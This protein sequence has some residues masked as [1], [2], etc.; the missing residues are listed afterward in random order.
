MS[1]GNFFL[2]FNAMPSSNS[3]NRT[4][5]LIKGLFISFLFLGLYHEGLKHMY[6]GWSKGD[7][8]Y[9]YI[10]PFVVLYLLWDKRDKLLKTPSAP[11]WKGLIA[12][13]PGLALFWL[14]ELGGEYFTLYLAAWITLVGI[15]WLH[16]GWQK[17]KIIRF[18]LLMIPAMFP[19]PNFFHFRL[20]L[21]LKLLS[22]RFG[23]A[24]MQWYGLS[25]FRQGN[26]IDLGFTQLQVV[27]A[28]N[29]IRYLFPLFFL[30]LL[31][32]YHTRAA[33]WKKA[34]L[35]VSTIPLAVFTNSLRIALTGI[36]YPYVGPAIVKGF[37]HD[38]AG[39]FIFMCSLGILIPEMW[40]LKRIFPDRYIQRMEDSKEKTGTD[41]LT[42]NI[43]H[44]VG[45]KKLKKRSQAGPNHGHGWFGS[46]FW[47][48]QFVVT[49][50]LL[51]ATWG[52]SQG[53]E[54][55]E[56]NPINRS[57]ASFPLEIGGWQGKRMTMNQQLLKELDLSD[58]LMA[59][60]IKPPNEIVNFYVAYYESQRKGQSIHSPATCLSGTG[61][62]F[63]E[64]GIRKI[65][66]PGYGTMS[67]NR[68]YMERNGHRQIT[69][70][71]FSMRGRIITNNYQLKFYN[72][73]DALTKQRTDGAL[74]RLITPLREGEDVVK[75]DQRLQE[76]MAAV[77]PV[78][79]EY[80]PGRD[81]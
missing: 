64:K 29:G 52:I 68:I 3:G 69:Y 81:A 67:V 30:G 36:L 15:V 31:L 61:W 18:A 51:A 27:D 25:A 57:F 75:G 10:I 39:W 65:Q 35:V 16:T 77:L 60:F 12:F 59:D 44:S 53:V 1:I 13:I 7:Y 72:F 56:K 43:G 73:W 26:V 41:E 62:I 58:Y 28:C 49:M 20:S 34:I 9:C 2:V 11:S 21:Q 19:L 74:V 42:P 55:R 45:N 63:R 33:L 23:V 80:I 14:G 37:F 79:D 47:P 66:V 8:S 54:F 76:F 50:V 5:Y 4:A 22:S 38:F 17:M 78:L 70:Y 40:F 6:A 32:A 71:W 48:P 24:M 46:F